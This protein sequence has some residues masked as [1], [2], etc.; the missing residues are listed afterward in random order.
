MIYIEKNSINSSILELTSVSSLINP[1]YLF[2]FINDMNPNQLTY[3]T[4][5]DLS[6]FKCRYNRF[7]ITETGSTYTNYT[8]ST[9]NLR[10]GSYQ[11]NVY[12]STAST[13]SVSATTGIVISTGKT[14]VVGV[15]TD[16]NS[17]YR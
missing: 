12:E 4:G 9:I 7:N 5:I 2:E 15:D 6:N 3:F 17:I 11:Y 14:L 10:T 1:S 8:A 16:I 13:L